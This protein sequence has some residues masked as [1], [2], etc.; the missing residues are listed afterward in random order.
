MVTSVYYL[1]SMLDLQKREREKEREK[2]R[3]KKKK[4]VSSLKC[5]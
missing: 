4:K 2:E 1:T 5:H 3:K